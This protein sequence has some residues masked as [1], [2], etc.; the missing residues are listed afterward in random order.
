[1]RL[2]DLLDLKFVNDLFYFILSFMAF[3]I[4]EGYLSWCMA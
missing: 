2:S 1:M 4:S 3:G